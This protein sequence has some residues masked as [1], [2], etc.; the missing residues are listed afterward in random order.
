[1]QIQG[2]FHILK[3][4]NLKIQNKI[5]KNQDYKIH[6]DLLLIQSKVPYYT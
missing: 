5:T 6:L 3:Y 1:M 4:L 2:R